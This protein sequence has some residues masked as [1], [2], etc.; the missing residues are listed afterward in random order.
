[1]HICPSHTHTHTTHPILFESFR[2][3]SLGK[4]SLTLWFLDSWMWD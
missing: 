4:K 2:L 3:L 1:M